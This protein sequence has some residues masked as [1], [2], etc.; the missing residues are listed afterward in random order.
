[1]SSRRREAFGLVLLLVVAAGVRAWAWS[2]TVVLFNDG[3]V[4]LS[5]ADA[6]AHGRWAEVFAH[7]YHPLYPFCVWVVGGLPVDPETAG[8]VVAIGGGVLAVAALTVFLRDAFG[9]EVAWLGGWMVA[10][11]PSAVD[12]SADVMSDGLYAGLFL[13]SFACLARAVARPNAGSALAAG[14]LAG[15]AYWVRP[16]GIGL[17]L[18]GCLLLAWRAL[19]DDGRGRGRALVAAGGLLAVALLVVLPYVSALAERSGDF[20]LTRKKSLTALVTGREPSPLRVPR[21]EPADI[22]DGEA[23]ALPSTSIA[24]PELA[25]RADGPGAQRPPRTPLG[26]LQ[27]FTRALRTTLSALRYE[28]LVFVVLGFWASRGRERG[29][30]ERTIVVVTVVYGAL[31]VLLVWG[32]GYV[33]RRHALAFVLPWIGFAAFG[34]QW[35]MG[36][37]FDSIRLAHFGRRFG[38]RDACRRSRWTLWALIVVLGLVWGPRDLRMRRADRAPV[39]AASEWLARHHPDSGPVASQKLRAAYYAGAPYVPLMS[40]LDG[41]LEQGLRDRGARWIVIDE[42]RFGDHLGI[43]EGI[44]EWLRPAYRAQV[45]TQAAVVLEILPSPAPRDGIWQPRRPDQGDRGDALSVQ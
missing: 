21:P 45:G 20:A 10:L 14:L 9:P 33:S 1:M 3:P 15:L 4:F 31:L 32:A 18:V 13:A 43:E 17:V 41:R 11:H 34:W 8:V 26:L 7:P 30:H 16:E 38:A 5:I 19:T 29:W 36:A 35:A 39:R 24:L 2:R 27:A 25:I 12:F 22:G 37:A 40:G 42:A 44:G 28:V 6:M 23:A